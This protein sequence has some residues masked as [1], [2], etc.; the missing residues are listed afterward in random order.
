MKMM[1]K[2]VLAT[3]LCLCSAGM[4][5]GA[6]IPTF[7]IDFYGGDS[8]LTEGV[9]DTNTNLDLAAGESVSVNILMSGIPETDRLDGFG[10][11]LSYGSGLEV[12]NIDLN[13]ENWADIS[14]PYTDTDI[15]CLGIEGL[16]QFSAE[17]NGDNIFMFS[18]DLTATSNLDP[19]VLQLL[20]LDDRDNTSTARL[21]VLDH[22]L[23]VDLATI[24][25]RDQVPVPA[26]V[27]LLG[28]GLTSLVAIRRRKCL[29]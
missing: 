14:E 9:F 13:A 7:D 12:S 6:I 15:G 11:R 28:S 1:S 16:S 23:P 5:M 8:G 10:F 22:H 19:W 18:F 20:D 26:A 29:K 25:A 27:W 4:A 24:N 2:L 21:E 3:A 17:L